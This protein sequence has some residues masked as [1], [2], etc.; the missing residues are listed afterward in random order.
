MGWLV[1]KI[2]RNKWSNASNDI[3]QLSADTITQDLKT[4]GNCLSVWRVDT[5]DAIDQAVL[6]LAANFDHINKVEV[7]VIAEESLQNRR[8]AIE[9]NQGNTPVPHLVHTHRDLSQLTYAQLGFVAQSIIE[10]LPNTKYYTQNQIKTLLREAIS[11]KQLDPNDLKSAVRD[12]LN[13]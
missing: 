9:P 10:S 13:N 2:T 8:I 1:R 11:T 12:K 7:V 4:V 5:S 3:C 6:A